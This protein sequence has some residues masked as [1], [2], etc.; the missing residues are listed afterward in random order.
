MKITFYQ[1]D[2]RLWMVLGNG[3][4]I[5]SILALPDGGF[6]YDIPKWKGTVPGEWSL[7]DL[8]HLVMDTADES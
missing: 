5:G 7:S 6:S 4:Q 2:S 8:Q 3:K 1:V